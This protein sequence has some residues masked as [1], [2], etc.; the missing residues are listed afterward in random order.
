MFWSSVALMGILSVVLL[1]YLD[2]ESRRLE[3]TMMLTVLAQLHEAIAIKTAE[4]KLSEPKQGLK[5]L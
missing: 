4:V 1:Y 2:R 5:T 3:A